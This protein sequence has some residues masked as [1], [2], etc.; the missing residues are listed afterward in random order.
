M[1]R[2][3]TEKVRFFPL[4]CF[5]PLIKND[6]MLVRDEKMALPRLIERGH[7]QNG[8]R[9]AHSSGRTMILK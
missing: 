7:S 5:T 6:R 9:T 8:T 2:E 3:E 4:F 1:I